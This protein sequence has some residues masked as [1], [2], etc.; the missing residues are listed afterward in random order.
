MVG[1]GGGGDVVPDGGSKHDN[2][3]ARQFS[4]VESDVFLFPKAEKGK[5]W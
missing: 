2:A 5:E 3:A 1:G 4:A